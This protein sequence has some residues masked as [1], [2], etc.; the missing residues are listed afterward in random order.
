MKKLRLGVMASGRGSKL[1]AI[2]DAA[3]AGRI[4]AEV[5]VV[6]SDKEDAFALERARKA[7]IPAE[8]VDPGKFNSKEDYEKVLVDILNRYEVGLVC[9]AAWLLGMAVAL[10]FNDWGHIK[11]FGLNIFDLLDTLTTKIMVPT[12]GLLIALFVGWRMQRA[13]VEDEI[14][15]SAGSFKLWFAVLR[16]LSPVAIVLIF[17]NVIG[18]IG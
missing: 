18:V 15:L 13:H 9:L 12:A 4:D 1:Q 11:L 14:A 10:S 16:Y 5:A 2:M 6:I 8:F 17:L 3:A 7:G